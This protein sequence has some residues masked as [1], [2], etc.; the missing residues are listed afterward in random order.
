L[1]VEQGVE[2]GGFPSIEVTSLTELSSRL[3][4]E[5]RR[6]S[7]PYII[8]VTGSV[9]KTTTVAFL[10]HLIR[11]AGY[12]VTRF[13]SKRLTPLLVQC[14]YINRVDVDTPFVVMEYSAY[15]ADH[16]EQLSQV[17]PPNIAFLSN[18]YDMH[19]NPGMFESKKDIFDSKIRIR[20]GDATGFINN[21]VLQELGMR[22]V[23]GWS[24]FSVDDELSGFNPHLPLTLRTAEL[25]TVGRILADNIGIPTD[26]F[27]RAFTTFEPQERRLVSV[28]YERA[29][30]FFD[31]EVTV[32]ARQ[33]SWFETLDGRVPTLMVDHIH[34]GDEDPNGYIKMLREIFASPETYVLDTESNRQSLPVSANFVDEQKFGSVFKKALGGYVVYHKAM[35]TRDPNFDPET[36]L[37]QRWN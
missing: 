17:L 24:N 29:R 22:D 30:V 1:A 12:P 32:G 26:T 21:A 20:P 28:Q 18:I 3:Y 34:F 15:G 33:W 19:I 27:R 10:E 9:G 11:E 6:K 13:W 16:V 25:H 2:T 31:G 14:H 36:Y 37:H 7:N 4:E 8:G 23:K 5:A 35:S